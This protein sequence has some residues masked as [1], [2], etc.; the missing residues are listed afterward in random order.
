MKLSAK[1]PVFYSLIVAKISENIFAMRK[2]FYRY[3]ENAGNH[4][5]DFFV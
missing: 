1:L 2:N 4:P 3:F 5:I